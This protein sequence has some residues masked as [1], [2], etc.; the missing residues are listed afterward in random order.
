MLTQ[1][2]GLPI[3]VNAIGHGAAAFGIAL[4]LCTVVGLVGLFAPS[5]SQRMSDV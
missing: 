3:G 2:I 4:V 5:T 1:L